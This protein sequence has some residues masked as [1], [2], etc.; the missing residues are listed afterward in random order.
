MTKT[1]DKSEQYNTNI[2]SNY[3][4]ELLPTEIEIFNEAYIADFIDEIF[5][6]FAWHG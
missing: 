6:G 5:S 4:K 1:H 2:Y 3:H